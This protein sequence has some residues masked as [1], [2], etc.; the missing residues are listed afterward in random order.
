MVELDRDVVDAETDERTE[1]V[2]DRFNRP[3]F[4]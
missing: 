2:F 1:Q 4:Q 3:V